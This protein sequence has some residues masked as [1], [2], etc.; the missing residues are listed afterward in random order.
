MFG[1]SEWEQKDKQLSGEAAQWKDW[2]KSRDAR[3]AQLTV[4]K[5]HQV[6]QEYRQKHAE[7]PAK[8]AEAE[9][10]LAANQHRKTEIE[11]TLKEPP[12]PDE[13]KHEKERQQGLGKGKGR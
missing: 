7:Q 3:L 6:K 10:R 12:Y 2:V 8:L 4:E 5:L 1:R 13:I 9:K 11:R